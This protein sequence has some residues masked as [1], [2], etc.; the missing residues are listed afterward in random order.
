MKYCKTCNKPSRNQNDKY[1][2]VCGNKLLDIPVKRCTCGNMPKKYDKFC[3]KCG[4][5][6]EV[7][8]IIKVDLK[9]EVK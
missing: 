4:K 2:R 3:R 1:C 9:T 8:E 7:V 5:S 6:V